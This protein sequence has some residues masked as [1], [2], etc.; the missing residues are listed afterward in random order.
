MAHR[1]FARCKT[2]SIKLISCCPA[3][4]ATTRVPRGTQ[5]A[6]FSG[7]KV[8][9]QMCWKIPPFLHFRSARW[10]EDGCQ[11]LDARVRVA[12]SREDFPHYVFEFVASTRQSIHVVFA[13]KHTCR[14]PRSPPSQRTSSTLPLGVVALILT[15]VAVSPIRNISSVHL[16][17]IQPRNFG[18]APGSLTP[19]SWVCH[20]CI[21][22]IVNG[23]HGR[24]AAKA[25][26][27]RRE[28]PYHH[29][30]GQAQAGRAG[31]AV[32]HQQRHQ[33][34]AQGR[35]AAEHGIDE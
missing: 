5:Q 34:T 2:V 11:N 20:S 27:G 19:S 8:V 28:Q 12:Q 15:L 9:A 18:L 32:C 4:C 14:L 6:N 31:S 29:P 25:R 13:T 17:F 23:S 16:F 21:G 7:C 1:H 24:T 33:Q 35:G 22:E 3:S 26:R 10:R 30:G